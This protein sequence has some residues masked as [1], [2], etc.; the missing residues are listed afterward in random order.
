MSDSLNDEVSPSVLD[1]SLA[2]EC[3]GEEVTRVYA[4]V[5]ASPD[6]AA[7]LAKLREIRDVAASRLVW[8][9]NGMWEALRGRLAEEEVSWAAPQR[10]SPMASAERASETP[11]SLRWNVRLGVSAL[12]SGAV[13]LTASW[14]F[15]H[16]RTASRAADPES[17]YITYTTRPGERAT[18]T[19]PDGNTVALNVASRLEVP[20]KY[21]AGYH[22]VRLVEGEALFTVAHHSATAFTVISGTTTTRVLGTSFVVRKYPTDPATTVAVDEGRVAV[23][24]LV[25]AAQH[26]VE[27]SPEGTTQ[28]RMANP[29]EFA[30]AS[31]TLVI[32][33]TTLSK[34]IPELDRWYDAEIRLG[35]P[36]LAGETFQGHFG[37]GSL[38]DLSTLLQMM[39]D[40]RIVRE[41]RVLTLYPKKL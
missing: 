41:G 13:I 6:H 4:W 26:L 14:A 3:S 29:S 17:A 12:V 7:E 16:V 34:E 10:R 31:G 24:R 38:A 33:P 28:V 18:V 2:G 11:R 32:R 20:V 1:R 27:I 23:G 35:D 30:F 15:A 22:T 25:V 36:A 37:A 5:A 8:N 19:L 9:V 21:R 40:V 39:F